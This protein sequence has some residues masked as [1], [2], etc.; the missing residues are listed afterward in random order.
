MIEGKGEVFEDPKYTIE[1]ILQRM[2]EFD[3]P[4]NEI[5]YSIVLASWTKT[6][7]FKKARDLAEKIQA[8][9]NIKGDVLFFWNSIMKVMAEE[10]DVKGARELYT[11]MPELCET[12]PDAFMDN[13]LL[14]AYMKGGDRDGGLGF[15]ASLVQNGTA[16]AN[17]LA[18]I[19]KMYSDPWPVYN[20]YVYGDKAR[21]V[22][23]EYI[24]ATMIGKY[25]GSREF[26]MVD[27]VYAEMR[28]VYVIT[29]KAYTL[30]AIL[31]ACERTVIDHFD[32]STP[33]PEYDILSLM[34]I[35][36][37]Y[38]LEYLKSNDSPTVATSNCMFSIS[39]RADR[40][41][42]LGEGQVLMNATGYYQMYFMDED[43]VPD[44]ASL[45]VYLENRRGSYGGEGGDRG[46]VGQVYGDRREGGVEL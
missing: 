10:G 43:V 30:E 25:V 26:D 11:R 38:Y 32:P 44:R 14:M 45:L 31:K 16:S 20:A 19:L 34:E 27:K 2:T 41:S 29:P 6:K 22:P 28:N 4:P 8:E 1:G 24:F 42:R 39:L 33:T 5:A 15:F 35:S 9:G 21:I 17:H 12:R 3:F 40:K 13:V 46:L 36:Q 18:T 37:R 23:D 7:Q